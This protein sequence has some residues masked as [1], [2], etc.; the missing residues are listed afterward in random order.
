MILLPYI[1]LFVLGVWANTETCLIRVPNYY[2]I[3]ID[4]A[5]F[6][7]PGIVRLNQSTYV[8]ETHPVLNIEDY[9]SRLCSLKLPYDFHNRE[10]SR[11]FVKI[12]N[13]NNNT[14][15]AN[16]LI[17]VKLCWPASSPFDFRVD[18]RF[19]ASKEL[20]PDSPMSQ[21]DIYVEI[22]YKGD[23]YA[24]TLISDT[25]VPVV[26]VL[27]KLP[28]RWIPIPIELY[29]YIMYVLDLLI[30]VWTGLPIVQQY[31]RLI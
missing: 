17:N 24:V 31:L 14:F 30:L 13:Y 21:L 6:N 12:N 9:N 19:I 2:T 23:F 11:V 18:Y 26:L 22:E 4:A 3:P 8:I 29:D 27:S 16:D 10:T 25:T 28:N 1:L 5:A 20:Y 15:D 7:R